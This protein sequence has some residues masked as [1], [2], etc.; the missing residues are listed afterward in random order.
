MKP[1]S[2]SA[3][4]SWPEIPYRTPNGHD[5]PYRAPWGYR[6]LSISGDDMIEVTTTDF[7]TTVLGAQGP[8]L[9]DFWAPW[10][11]PCRAMEPNLKK[12]AA[13]TPDLVVVK[14]DVEANEELKDR[15]GIAA[16]PT[17]AVFSRGQ[18]VARRTGAAGLPVLRDLVAPFLQG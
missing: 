13:L 8:V 18:E 12:L 1:S 17:L 9:V 5:L 6:H 4:R 14:V 7:D 11:G 15:F 3:E 16:I 10:C 2:R